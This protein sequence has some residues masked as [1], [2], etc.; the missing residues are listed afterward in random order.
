MY[1]IEN[2]N[3][4]LIDP[5]TVG[6]PPRTL[7]GQLSEK[8][9]VI[10]KD[11]KSRIIMKD[12]KQILEQVQIVKKQKPNAEVSLV[13]TAPVCSKTTK[14]LLENKIEIMLLEKRK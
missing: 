13:T 11:R 12:G 1:Q 10:I 7:L 4:L 14:F 9:F 8:H 3:I 6:L 2:R 5:E